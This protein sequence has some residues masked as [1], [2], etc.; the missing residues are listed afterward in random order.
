MAKSKSNL[1]HELL[2][3]LVTC[4]ELIGFKLNG[5][6]FSKKSDY[7]W[8]LIDWQTSRD[9]IDGHIKFTVNLGIH[10]L[11]LAAVLDEVP[12]GRRLDVW[13]CHL[14]ERIGFLLPER[15]DKWWIVPATTPVSSELVSEFKSLLSMYVAPFFS[16]FSERDDLLNL[17]KSGVAPGQT[18]RRRIEFI[19][20]L[21][22][23]M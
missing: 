22:K 16:K 21:E 18:D 13:S 15:K 5:N 19:D 12:D 11:R 7:Y 8:F 2:T 9:Q 10:D 17:W 23:M 1:L 14:N 20:R 4:P 3:A 6:T